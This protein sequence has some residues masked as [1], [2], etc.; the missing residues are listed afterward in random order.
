MTFKSIANIFEKLDSER[1]VLYLSPFMLQVTSLI[2]PKE[3]CVVRPVH[4]LFCYISPLWTLIW[5]LTHSSL[6]ILPFSIIF[7]TMSS[8]DVRAAVPNGIPKPDLDL[9]VGHGSPVNVRILRC[10]F[11][12]RTGQRLL[13][14][15]YSSLQS[16]RQTRAYI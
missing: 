8:T 14:T 6:L 16:L 10:P 2:R 15:I 11:S 5:G 3:R 4:L 13:R 7:P 12:T 9:P 1:D